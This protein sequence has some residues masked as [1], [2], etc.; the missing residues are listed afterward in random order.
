MLAKFP[1]ATRTASSS[2]LPAIVAAGAGRAIR[3]YNAG[4]SGRRWAP[5]PMVVAARSTCRLGMERLREPWRIEHWTIAA[6][7]GAY[8]A[9]VT[10]FARNDA[11][12]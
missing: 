8:I 7:I 3:A 2:W 6:G 11:L 1:P 5:W 9:G 12:L 4:L 10:W